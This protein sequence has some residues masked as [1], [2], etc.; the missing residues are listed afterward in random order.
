M[1]RLEAGNLTAIR[2]PTPHH[3]INGTDEVVSSVYRCT[4]TVTTVC[5]NRILNV[6]INAGYNLPKTYCAK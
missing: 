3:L 2:V 5:H 4:T 6:V 1:K